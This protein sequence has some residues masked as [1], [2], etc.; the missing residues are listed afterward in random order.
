M[1]SLLNST[2]HLKNTNI[3]KL[4]QTKKKKKQKENFPVYSRRP[5][6]LPKPD[7]QR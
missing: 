5:V 1:A 3:H 7:N 4:F 2:K 6:S